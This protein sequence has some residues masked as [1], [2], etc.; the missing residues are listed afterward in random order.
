[1]KKLLFAAALLMAACSQQPASENEKMVDVTFDVSGDFSLT[2]TPI[3]TRTLDA[4]GKSMTDV[5]VLDYV[6]SELKQQVHQ[7][8]T[9]ADFGSPTLRLSVGAHTLYFV[10]SRG[11][12]AAL[13]T[14]ARTMSF[15]KVNDTFWAAKALNVSATTTGTQAVA[16]DRIATKLRITFSDAIPTGAATFNVTPSQWHYGFNYTTGEPT[17]ATVSQ[18]I[19]VNIPSSYIGLVGQSVSLFGFSGS[20]DFTTDV[21][22]DCQDADSHVLGAATVPSVQIK[23]NRISALTGSLFSKTATIGF[24]L[25][26]DWLDDYEMTF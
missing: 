24:T 21:A 11:T 7:T 19:T 25:N 2:I 1:M 14:D 10:A 22:I 17:T 15:A 18:P 5:W 6:G 26:T 9:D 13:D 4:D 12:D 8:A 3:A 20:D 16:L 23:R